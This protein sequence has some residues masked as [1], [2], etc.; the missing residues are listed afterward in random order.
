MHPDFTAY[1]DHLVTTKKSPC[2][3]RPV[4]KLDNIKTFSGR[5]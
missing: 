1:L 5:R 2:T 4:L 3:V